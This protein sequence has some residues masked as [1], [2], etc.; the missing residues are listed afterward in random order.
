MSSSSPRISEMR[1]AIHLQ[2]KTVSKTRGFCGLKSGE[3]QHSLFHHLDIDLGHVHLPR[4]LRRELCALQQL[5][6]N[7]GCHLDVTM[8]KKSEA[9]EERLWGEDVWTCRR[10]AS[11]F[12]VSKYC[13]D[14]VKGGV[15]RAF[16]R[17]SLTRGFLQLDHEYRVLLLIELLAVS[18]AWMIYQFLT[19]VASHCKR[20][21]HASGFFMFLCSRTA[22]RA[23][24]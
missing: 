12:A 20:C 22:R 15:V 13:R 3:R 16:Y 18:R 8:R 21:M 9:K 19:Y 23:L 14:L 17:S 24:H 1:P 11:Y 5:R 4:E 7:R 6:V 10:S 2:H